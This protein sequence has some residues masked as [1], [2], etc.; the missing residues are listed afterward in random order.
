[1]FRD[2]LV[3]DITQKALDQTG[4]EADAAGLPLLQVGLEKLAVTGKSIH[5]NIGYCLRER[6]DLLIIKLLRL[7]G[8]NPVDN[9]D[10]NRPVEI[11]HFP[12]K[13]LADTAQKAQNT[14]NS[15]A[16]MAYSSMDAP[17]L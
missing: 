6:I 3:Q 17:P 7:G 8:D 2:G 10:N 1:V 9:A 4:K 11:F 15:F 13:R 12:L 14:S 16:R 5:K